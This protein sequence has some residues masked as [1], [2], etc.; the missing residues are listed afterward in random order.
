[1]TFS[2]DNSASSWKESQ[3]NQQR[4]RWTTILV[5]FVYFSF[6]LTANGWGPLFSPLATT[7]SLT[8]D[9][10]GLLFVI[11]SIGYLPGVLVGGALLDRYGPRRVLCFALCLMGG[12]LTAILLGLS[13]HVALL[14]GVLVCAGVAGVGGGS[15]DASTNGVISG[16]Y[17]QQRGRAL[18]LFTS[19]YPLS[20]LLISLIDGGLL[21]LFPTDP[22]PPLLLTVCVVAMALLAALLLPRSFRQAENVVQPEDSSFPDQVGVH[23]LEMVWL[24]LPIII[25]MMLTTGFTATIRVWTPTY[26]HIRYGQ[27]ASLA[28]VLGGLTNGLAVVFRLVT[29]VIIKRVGATRVVLSGILVALGG[30]VT[31]LWSP[32]VLVGTIAIS[33]TVVGLTPLVA[34]FVSIGSDRVGR[35]FGSVAGAL[36]FVAG[37]SNS[38]CSWLFGVILG[39]RGP[40][41]AVVFCLIALLGG[42]MVVISLQRERVRREV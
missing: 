38:L 12:S 27:T 35:L 1:M 24:L 22:R 37:I 23:R 10:V 21:A 11:W 9:Q 42:A 25:A 4:K 17:P 13:L 32:T 31:L 20:S 26:L 30:L 39:R 33:V 41:W 3:K 6:A 15:I 18:N 19:L 14:G 16:L 29:V 5:S 8:L 28:A 40:S 34:T 2:S 7:L 36:F